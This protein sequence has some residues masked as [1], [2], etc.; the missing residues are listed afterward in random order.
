M[1]YDT[2][3]PRK[4]PLLTQILAFQKI[5]Y[6]LIVPLI[7]LG[8]AGLLLPVLPGLALIFGGVLLWKP[9]FAERMKTRILKSVKE[10]K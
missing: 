7:L 1:N 4:E 5:K 8:V 10:F 3:R 9:E 2:S 6:W